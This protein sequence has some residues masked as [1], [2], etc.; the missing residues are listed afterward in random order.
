MVGGLALT[1][2]LCLATAGQFL[3][4]AHPGG[5]RR[6]AARRRAVGAGARA[7]RVRRPALGRLRHRVS[8]AQ[9][10]ARAGHAAD[11]PRVLRPDPGLRVRDAARLGV[12]QPR[13]PVDRRRADDAGV[14]VPG[15]VPRSGHVARGRVE[16]PDAGQPRPR[17]SRCSARCCCSPSG[18]GH[19]GEGMA[20]L[21]WTRFMQV[22]PQLHPFTLR[23]G[24]VFALIG[25]GTKAGLAPMH[26]WKPDAYRE[27][28]SPAVR[29]DGRRHAERRAVL[30]P[31]DPPD[32]EGGARARSSP[33]A[34]C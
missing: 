30:H 14:G 4:G 6:R 21:H 17:R 1:F 26:T 12:E 11:A 32:F 22:A 16:V 24:V 34:C 27:A 20:A 5:V 8:A 28:P 15:H 19:L 13:H 23:L 25:Y 33:A 18:Q 31:A 7:L 10:G 29:A 2:G 9:R 3:G